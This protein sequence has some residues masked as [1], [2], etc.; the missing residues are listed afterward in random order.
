MKDWK[1][2]D[3]RIKKLHQI[4][5]LRVY[6]QKFFGKDLPI[7]QVN[8]IINYINNKVKKQVDEKPRN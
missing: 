1:S 2:F 7:M 4:L 8:Q 6:V 3:E 5:E